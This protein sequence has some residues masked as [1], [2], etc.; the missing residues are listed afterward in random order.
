M[1]EIRTSG[2]VE[3]PGRVISLVYSTQ[4]SRSVMK[5]LIL[6]VSNQDHRFSG[7]SKPE[8]YRSYLWFHRIEKRKSIRTTIV[9]VV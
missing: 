6:Y 9:A 4:S 7:I 8:S 3:G 1:R 5:W 2:S